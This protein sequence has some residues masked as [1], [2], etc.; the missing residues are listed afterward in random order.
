MRGRI[1]LRHL[2]GAAVVLLLVSPI[3]WVASDSLEQDNE[4][5]NACHLEDGV[6]FHIDL[7]RDFD[8]R[9]P[10]NLS[11]LHAASE[12]E[13]R[14]DDPAFRCID[15]HGGVGLVGRAKVKL[16]AAKDTAVWLAGLGREPDEMHHPLRDADC[17]QCHESFH[18]V[19]DDVGLP[20]FHE[21]AVH[22][23][24]LG[25]DCVE[26]HGAHLEGGD[27]SFYFLSPESVRAK[28]AHC[29]TE[30]EN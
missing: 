12:V 24:E 19:S 26:C 15:C 10:T 17:T 28:C 30:F 8:T 2:G 23:V 1:R 21:I 9:P 14:A 4:F 13:G 6:R 3:G 20:A 16:L 27:P 22:N 29:H 18:P 25:Q 7:R 11:A 5:C